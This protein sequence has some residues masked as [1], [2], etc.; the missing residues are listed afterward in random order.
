MVNDMTYREFFLEKYL[1]AI[2]PLERR[3]NNKRFFRKY[4]AQVIGALDIEKIQPSHIQVVL[5]SMV[6]AGLSK[7]SVK[8]NYNYMKCSF[9]TAIAQNIIH[10]NPCI[11]IFNKMC[12]PYSFP[13]NLETHKLVLDSIEKLPL[14][15]L[16][17]FSY[18]TGFSILELCSLHRSD[19]DIKNGFIHINSSRHKGRYQ[20]PD[21]AK[22]YVEDE[23]KKQVP[24]S[25]NDMLFTLDNGARISNF[26]TY[27]CNNI[28]K[29]LLHKPDFTAKNLWLGYGNMLH[30]TGGDI[31]L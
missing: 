7:S 11:V 31:W 28:L 27:T 15:N 19:Y 30:L 18:S 29:N 12:L 5:N 10:R 14:R 22:V 21:C 24:L 6:Q 13:E 20:I 2:E 1:P 16:F 23:F 3:L 9:K 17:G 4:A 8:A 26:H 25:K